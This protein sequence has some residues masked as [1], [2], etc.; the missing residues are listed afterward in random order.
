MLEP[1][2]I[3][4]VNPCSHG[5]VLRS[6]RY[7]VVPYLQGKH[8]KQGSLGPSATVLPGMH[9]DAHTCTCMHAHAHA[10]TA[11]VA[12]I[13]IHFWILSQAWYLG[14]CDISFEFTG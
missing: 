2:F 14:L 6:W 7:F 9:T 11:P 8:A 3:P 12:V 4:Q 1:L 10:H 13:N 5:T